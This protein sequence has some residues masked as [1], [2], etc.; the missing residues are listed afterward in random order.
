MLT[1]LSKNPTIGKLAPSKKRDFI[2]I[3]PTS[4]YI[5]R[6][7]LKEEF[8]ERIPSPVY[9]SD[10]LIIDEQIMNY[11]EKIPSTKKEIVADLKPE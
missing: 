10:V 4:E 9:A 8:I 5:K 7:P 2:E 11:A 1:Q 6:Y 3:L